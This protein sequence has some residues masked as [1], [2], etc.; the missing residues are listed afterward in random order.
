MSATIGTS[1]EI[2]P[3][4]F[5]K[6]LLKLSGQHRTHVHKFPQS[7]KLHNQ[8]KSQG[9]Y[10]HPLHSRTIHTT[11]S[12]Y[13]SFRFRLDTLDFVLMDGRPNTVA[14]RVDPRANEGW[15]Y[16]TSVMTLTRLF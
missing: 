2:N 9:R 12:G 4:T 6:Y 1:Q 8:S 16:G 7:T 14:V 13:T 3:R 5:Q 11:S 15:F 10:Q